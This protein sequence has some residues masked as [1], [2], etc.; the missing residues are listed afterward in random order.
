MVEVCVVDGPF[1]TK[2]HVVS[3]GAFRECVCDRKPGQESV[4]PVTQ[5]LAGALPKRDFSV[6]HP[7]LGQ[8]LAEVPD[9]FGM[10]G[11]VQAL[12]DMV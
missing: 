10:V 12:S 9:N 2:G 6:D 4:V 3:P 7:C 5:L 8:D 11:I 1:G